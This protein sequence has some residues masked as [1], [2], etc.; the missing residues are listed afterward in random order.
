MTRREFAGA[1]AALPL[2]ARGVAAEKVRPF[3]LKRVRLGSGRFKD[4]MELNRRYLHELEVD[5]LLHM[6]RVTAGLPSPAEPLGGWERPQNEL[7]GHFLGHY[8]SACAAGDA[9]FERLGDVLDV[10]SLS[11]REVKPATR[12]RYAVSSV[13]R[14]GNE[15]ARSE[16]VEVSVP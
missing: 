2:A 16:P 4:A 1:V 8:L 15:S 9:A 13:D 3:D 7:R 11:D 12:Y 14:S 6:F 5:R 10:P